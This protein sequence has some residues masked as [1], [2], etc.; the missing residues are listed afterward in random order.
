MNDAVEDIWEA[1]WERM[2]PEFR[3]PNFQVA[4]EQEARAWFDSVI[5]ELKAKAW[6]EGHKHCF[7]VENP[8]AEK[9]YNP[10]R[11]AE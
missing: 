6:D 10:Y 1:Y 11:R 3:N 7:H 8:K 5:R 2:D 9:P 4:A